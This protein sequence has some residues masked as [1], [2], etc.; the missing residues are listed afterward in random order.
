[1]PDVGYVYKDWPET[2]EHYPLLANPNRWYYTQR[3]GAVLFGCVHITA[4]ID[5]WDGGD[6]SAEASIRYGQTCTRPASWSAIVDADTAQ[7]CLPDRYV[8]FAQ[9]VSGSPYSYN[10]HGYG[11]EIGARSTDWTSKPDWWVEVVLR[12]LAAVFAPRC[13]RYGIRPVHVSLAELN[14]DLAAG[15][16]SGLIEHH[17]IDRANRSDA[18][19]FRGRETFPWP[20]FL[21]YLREE[22][23]RLDPEEIDM[24]LTPE[25]LTKIRDLVKDELASTLRLIPGRVWAYENLKH[26]KGDAWLL[27]RKALGLVKDDRPVNADGSPYV[28]EE[29]K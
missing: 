5:D 20:Q 29:A 9:G 21:G 15:R 23:N 4:G 16:P 22:I 17:E 12:R 8:A 1:M 14:A 2:A 10:T 18:G 26:A 27:L 19:L 28:P 13:I 11:V 25:D 3:R 24:P 7:D 6:G